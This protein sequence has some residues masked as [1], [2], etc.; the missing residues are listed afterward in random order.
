MALRIPSIIALVALVLVYA[1]AGAQ[2]GCKPGEV[3]MYGLCVQ[4]G[5]TWLDDTRQSETKWQDNSEANSW[6]ATNSHNWNPAVKS[7]VI[8]GIPTASVSPPFRADRLVPAR[9]YVRPEDI[10]PRQVGA[11]GIVVLHGRPTAADR[12]RLVMACHSFIAYLPRQEEIPATVSVRDLMLTI[13]PLDQ[14]SAA[15]AKSDDCNYILDHYALFAAESAIADARRQGAD[16]SG[17]GPFLVGWSPSDT[18]GK[19]DK[20]V[21]V[22]DMSGFET[23]DRFDRVF[24][25]WKQKIVENPQLWRSGW[26]LDGVRL[27]VRDFADHYGSAILSVVHLSSSSS[28]SD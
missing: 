1:I 4:A 26:S 17:E 25:L 24:M 16:F 12:K 11:Y 14:P 23:Q 28:K 27:A 15:Q 3:E 22:L 7:Q 19:P 18:R 5:H 6:A 9:A 20:L 13:W 10:P 8:P 2:A 21:L